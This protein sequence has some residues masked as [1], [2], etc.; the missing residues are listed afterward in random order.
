LTREAFDQSRQRSGY[1]EI[2]PIT[3]TL[4]SSL[5]WRPAWGDIQRLTV[6]GSEKRRDRSQD[7]EREFH[8]RALVKK[9][10]GTDERGLTQFQLTN[11][12]GSILLVIKPTPITPAFAKAP[13]GSFLFDPKRKLA[14]RGG[15]AASGWCCALALRAPHLRFAPSNFVLS[16]P[17][18][19]C[20]VSLRETLHLREA[21]MAE[22]MRF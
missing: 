5:I 16:P 10:T 1:V 19:L 15:L 18:V 4:N 3:S 6:C 14:E 9:A 12:D 13:A 21:Q 20:T 22:S 7:K 11:A 17:Q 8:G 2:H